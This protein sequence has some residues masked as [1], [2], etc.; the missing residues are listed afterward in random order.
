MSQKHDKD[1]I[2]EDELKSE[3]YD[4]LTDFIEQ[5]ELLEEQKEEILEDEG[6]IEKLQDLLSRT[7]ADFDNFRKRTERDKADMLH[8]LRADILKKILPRLDDLERMIDWTPEDMRQWALYDGIIVLQKSLLKDLEKMGVVSFISKWN[9]LNPDLHE[10]M[11]QVP[12]WDGIVINEFEK[13]YMLWEKVLRVAKVVV[14][15]G[16]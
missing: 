9:V 13:G 14:G 8:F 15:N 1:E 10:V 12:W 11:T 2:M 16:Q 7:Q 3:T 6:K 4:T 5:E